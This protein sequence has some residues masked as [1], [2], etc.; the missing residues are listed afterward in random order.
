MNIGSDVRNNV[1]HLAKFSLKHAAIFSDDD[2]CYVDSRN[3]NPPKPTQP[4]FELC[5]AYMP[6]AD[7]SGFVFDW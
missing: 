1:F 4:K 5:D 3:P 2:R 7:C 6:I